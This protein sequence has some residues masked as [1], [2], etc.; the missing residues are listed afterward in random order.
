MAVASPDTGSFSTYADR[1]IGH[2][3]GFTIGWLYWWF[4]VLVEHRAER[5]GEEPDQD[6]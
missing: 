3:A 6:V 1:A 4:W 5:L 2:W